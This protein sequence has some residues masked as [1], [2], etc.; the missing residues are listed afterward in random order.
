MNILVILSSCAQIPGAE[1]K[2]GTWFEELAAPYY[3][4][5]AAGAQVTLASPKGGA[6]PIDPGSLD[7]NFQSD[8]TRRFSADTEAHAVLA[9]TRALSMIR[10]ENYDAVFYSGGLGPVFDDL[11]PM[12]RFLTPT[13]REKLR[14]SWR[15]F[16]RWRSISRLSGSIAHPRVPTTGRSG[17][18]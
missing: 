12:R 7:D 15:G 8:A 17:R 9:N 5:R 1:R 4:F 16:I 18:L 13:E 10:A 3:L 14:D 6:A 2:T 11:R